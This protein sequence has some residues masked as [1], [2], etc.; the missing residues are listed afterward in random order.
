MSVCVCVLC[1]FFTIKVANVKKY[2]PLGRL[3]QFYESGRILIWPRQFRLK[4][5]NVYVV[6]YKI[7]THKRTCI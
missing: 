5:L 6:N 2:L 4:V 7:K 3:A 1:V